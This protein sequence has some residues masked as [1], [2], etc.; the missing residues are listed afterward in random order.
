MLSMLCMKAWLEMRWRLL[1]SLIFPLWPLSFVIMN[2]RVQH[3]EALVSTMG[4]MLALGSMYVAGTGIKTQASLRATKGVHGSLYFTLSLPV[5]RLR[6]FAVRVAAGL[7][8]GALLDLIALSV[9]WTV[10]PSIHADVSLASFVR[11]FLALVFCTAAFHALSVLYATFL[12]ET[13]QIWGS[14]ITIMILWRFASGIF[15]HSSWNVFYVLS[16][17]S[18]LAF[19]SLPL[20]AM[21]V[22]LAAATIFFAAAFTVLNSQEY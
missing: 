1:L 4:Y 21:A 15:P 16:A 3:P 2:G 6:L 8:G 11:V 19:H 10:I 13:W 18:P 22:S 7:V 20:G 12:D 14:M 9:V 17:L 5:S